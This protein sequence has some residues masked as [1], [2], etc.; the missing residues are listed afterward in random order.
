MVTEDT[1]TEKCGRTTRG[2]RA[3]NQ[4]TLSHRMDA[5]RRA[6][7]AT[8]DNTAQIGRAHV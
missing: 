4:R 5:A 3:L 7:E 8:T 2:G 6:P 1:E